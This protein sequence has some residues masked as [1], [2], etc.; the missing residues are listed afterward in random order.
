MAR[1]VWLVLAGAVLSPAAVVTY[2]TWS[3]RHAVLR[4]VPWV[5]LPA[6]LAGAILTAAGAVA[7]GRAGGRV[8]K[9]MGGLATLWSF[10][11]LLLLAVYVFDLSYRLPGPTEATLGLER[12]PDFALPDQEGRVVGLADLAGKKLVIVFFRGSW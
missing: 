8:A 10:A 6:V 12:A 9:L 11:W 2:F 4:D 3:A 1:G 7:A 5:N